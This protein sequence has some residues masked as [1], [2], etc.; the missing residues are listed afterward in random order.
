MIQWRK[1]LFALCFFM[2]A[3][4]FGAVVPSS[5]THKQLCNLKDADIRAVIQSISILTGKNFLIDPNVQGKITLITQK[6]MAPDELYHVFLSMLQTLNF[7]AVPSGN[8]I[9]IVPAMQA[10]QFNLPIATENHPGQ[11]DEIVVRVVS[12]NNTSAM[13]L[14]PILQPLM[15][16]WG[17]VSAY[18]PS[19]SLILTG[20]ASNIVRLVQIVHNMDGKNASFIRMLHLKH[21]NAKHIVDVI[22]HLQDSD[23][24]LGKVS[25]ISLAPDIDDNSI[26]ISANATNQNA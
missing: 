26:L 17:N 16:Q 23:R 11:G 19:N 4:A 24:S 12:I 21:A 18:A 5:T 25:N 13:Q 15:Q 8:I 10:K 14:V 2:S 3:L 20:T 1:W 22:N 6:P 7:A 9:K